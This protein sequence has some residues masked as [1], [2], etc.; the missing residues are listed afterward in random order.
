MECFHGLKDENLTLEIS[1]R[2]LVRV[3]ETRLLGVKFQENLKWNDH[4]KDI[5]NAS[6]GVLRTLRKLK[7]FTDFHLRKRLADSLVLSRLNYCDSVYSPLPGYLL[8]RLQKIEFAATSFVYGRYVNDIGDILKLNWLPVK[9]RRD[10]NLPKFTFKAVHAK[11][12]PSYLNLQRVSI[13]R[14][15]RSSDC[16][17]LQV[18]LEK[19]TF[20]DTAAAL[21]NNLPDNLKKCDYF[22]LFSSCIFLILKEPAQAS[23]S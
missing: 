19:G 9:E 17:R 4:V 1:N 15:L 7:H 16:I 18:P 8:K 20:Q 3:S 11:Q 13:R 10:F 23:L 5:A 12:W 21:F 22:N 14:G 2:Q 6:Y